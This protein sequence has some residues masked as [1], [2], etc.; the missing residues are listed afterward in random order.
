MFS[1]PVS[2]VA[3]G[4]LVLH[5]GEDQHLVFYRLERF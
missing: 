1:V 5:V 4:I 2:A 3:L